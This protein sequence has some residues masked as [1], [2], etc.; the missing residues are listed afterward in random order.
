MYN[1]VIECK[2][3]WVF[4]FEGDICVSVISR[5]KSFWKSASSN[6]TSGRVN[7]DVWRMD[8]QRLL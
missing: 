2:E 1:A 4:T 8:E 3:A 5:Y 7:L 6:I